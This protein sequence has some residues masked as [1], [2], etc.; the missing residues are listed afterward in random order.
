MHAEMM[1]AD[2]AD[3]NEKALYRIGGIAALALGAGYLAIFPL[4]AL[5]GIPPSGGA[6][7]LTYLAGKTGI[8][9]AILGVS[10]LTD[11]L[12]LPLA[13]ALYRA[14]RHISTNLMLLATA[15]VGLF[16]VL[17]L[18]VTWTNYAALLTLSERYGAATSDAERTVFIAAAS[19][20]SAV[21]ASGLERVYAILVLSLAILAIGFVML[22]SAFSR[23]TA[24]V[25]VIT[26]LLGIA[27]LTGWS[28]AII[29]NAIFAT[30]WIFLSGYRLYRLGRR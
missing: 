15:F 27:S 23:V 8:W 30:I 26:G 18:A 20:A 9:W 25:A 21:L 5:V 28:V 6:A 10:V 2:G 4:F 11:I 24:Y 12:F 29:L 14:L 3:A 13:F 17:D 19:Y 16:V 22:K 7:W 1:P